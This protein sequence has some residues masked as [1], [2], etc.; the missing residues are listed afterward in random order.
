MDNQ[1]LILF[2]ALSFILLLLWQ[3]W[4]QDYAPQ[5]PASSADT[6]EDKASPPPTPEDIPATPPVDGQTVLNEQLANTPAVP[7]ELHKSLE[8]ARRVHVV[9]DLLDVEIDTIGGDIRQADLRAYPVTAKTPDKPFQ[10]MQDKGQHIFIA[11]SGLL[12]KQQAVTHHT[13][14]TAQKNEYRLADD[15]DK[16]EV[17]LT[18]RGADGIT[19]VKTYTFHRNSYVIELTQEV[20]NGSKIEWSGHAYRQFQRTK[21]GEDEKSSFIRTYTGGVIY[22]DENKYEKIKFDDMEKQD[23]S[24]DIKSGW[25]A[26]IQH[27]FV[28]AWIPPAGETDH[29]YSKAPADHPYVLGLVSPEVSVGAGESARFTSRLY[30]GPKEQHRL[31]KVEPGLKLTVDYGVLTVIAQPLFWLMEKIHS[32]LGNWGWS[33]VILTM[34][35]KLVFYKLSETSYKSMANMRRLQPKIQA[36][37]ER[38]GDDR[39]RMSQA[40]MEMYKK[41]KINPLGGCLPILVQIPFF[42]ALYWVLLESVELRQAPFILWINDLSIK[43]PYYVLP[44]LMG[45]TMFLQQQL[46]PAPPDPVQAKV[47]KMLPV[48]FTAFFAFF[49]S[50]LVLYWV[51]NSLLSILQ[52]WIITRRIE[53]AA[54]K[55]T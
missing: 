24:R 5:T 41:E 13:L 12:S 6:A 1:K 46:N 42:I 33:I 38:Y 2:F 51:S 19:V 11:Q 55:S 48:I 10:L 15:Q 50:G 37:R 23:L 36:L 43:D 40:M 25:A 8:S 35:I 44:L 9:T 32:L 21:P 39:Q 52:Q 20:Q 31:E 34:C 22:S 17:P 18:W 3:A 26:M 30:V 4:Q 47:M 29:Y 54:N 16:I 45:A 7:S 49:P 14:L 53:K 27:Y 28:S